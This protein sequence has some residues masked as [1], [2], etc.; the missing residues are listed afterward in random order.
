M[1]E[2]AE[3]TMNILIVNTF[4]EGGGAEKVARQLYYGLSNSYNCNM[5]FVSGRGIKTE[6]VISIIYNKHNRFLYA[7]NRMKNLISNNARKR[8]LLAKNVIIKCIKKY[9]IDIV[10]FH[11]IHGN[12]IGISDIKEISKYCKVI[13]TLHDMWAIT[14]HC[15]YSIEC[16][17]WKNESCRNCQNLTYYP[18]MWFDR[19]ENRL[20]LKE[21][22]FINGDIVFVAPSIWLKNLCCTTFLK[23]EKIVVINNGVDTNCFKPL[24]KENL[25]RKYNIPLKKIVLMFSA[26][27]C[28]S[29]YKGFDVLCSA[30]KMIKDKEK[31]FILMVGNGEKRE[32]EHIYECKY[33][34][35]VQNDSIMN[36]LYSMS[37][38]LIVPSRAENFPC[39]ILESMAAGTP[40]I[41]SRTGGIVEQIDD[42]TGWVFDVGDSQQLAEIISSLPDKKLDDM[43]VRCREKV[44]TFFSDKDMLKK[45][46]ELYEQEA[47]K[48][49]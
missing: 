47:G 38:V 48:Y 24:D 16:N 19:A 36:E 45:Y 32:I 3:V 30:L 6:N 15:A 28:D 42:K 34:G 12:Y 13:W 49:E 41:G 8:D 11:N 1:S 29:P 31:Y 21:K 20:H 2:R 44:L 7:F 26:N 27:A 43:H 35:Y 10:H 4:F 17:K 18:K 23:T 46:Y 22:T 14:G 37:D 33:M 25:R 9:H 5:Y 40:V 39:T